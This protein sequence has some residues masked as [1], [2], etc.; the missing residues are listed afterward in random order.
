MVL[1]DVVWSEQGGPLL[2]VPRGHRAP[3]TLQPRPGATVRGGL[4]GGV[5]R[6]EL[7]VCRVEVVGIECHTPNGAAVVVDLEDL[8]KLDLTRADVNVGSLHAVPNQC[9]PVA[10]GAEQLRRQP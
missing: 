6:V 8:K 9:E 2:P 1:H 7:G 10:P 5:A 4:A 3:E